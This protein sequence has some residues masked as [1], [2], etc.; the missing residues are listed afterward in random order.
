MKCKYMYI[1]NYVFLKNMFIFKYKF[2]VYGI[3]GISNV[4][5][6]YYSI[7]FMIVSNIYFNRFIY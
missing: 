5:F 1:L 7:I 3:Y 4:N 2:N 6:V